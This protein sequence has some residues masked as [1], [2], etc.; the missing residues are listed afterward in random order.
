MCQTILKAA[1]SIRGPLAVK[2]GTGLNEKGQVPRG[3]D[4]PFDDMNNIVANLMLNLTRYNRSGCGMI[5]VG[6]V[7][8]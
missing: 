2:P 6:V 8:Y 1:Q 3:S 5:E 7:L 4:K